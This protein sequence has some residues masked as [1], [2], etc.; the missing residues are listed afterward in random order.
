MCW[1]C[2]SSL[3]PRLRRHLSFQIKT[4]VYTNCSSVPFPAPEKIR[5]TSDFAGGRQRG[6]LA[7]SSRGGT[8][9]WEDGAEFR[10]GHSFLQSPTQTGSKDLYEQLSIFIWLSLL[11]VTHKFLGP[12]AS[13]R[14]TQQLMDPA[15]SATTIHLFRLCTVQKTTVAS[16]GWLTE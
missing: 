1:Q 15:N 4:C 5:W 12:E 6:N 14:E 7:E 3:N 8:E 13:T 11:F 10:H 16:S 2:I 9:R